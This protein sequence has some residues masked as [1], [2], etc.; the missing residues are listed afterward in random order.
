MSDYYRGYQIHKK[1]GDLKNEAGHNWT[2]GEIQL[3]DK[4]RLWVKQQPSHP[5]MLKK[6]HEM[7]DAH[8]SKKTM[9][10]R[11]FSMRLT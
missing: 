8:L 5:S 3:E 2:A 1:P 6:A 9:Y 10:D 4:T 11:F 7:I